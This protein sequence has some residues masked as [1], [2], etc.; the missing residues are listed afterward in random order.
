MTKVI[1]VPGPVVFFFAGCGAA[2]AKHVSVV[3]LNVQ[4]MF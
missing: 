3:G 4:L 2:H 1:G